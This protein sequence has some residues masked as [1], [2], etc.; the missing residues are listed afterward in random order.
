MDGIVEFDCFLVD[1]KC[2]KLIEKV[3]PPLPPEEFHKQ[4]NSN[5]KDKDY[6]YSKIQEEA[7][8]LGHHSTK[9]KSKDT[10]FKLSELLQPFR[11][12]IVKYQTLAT[13]DHYNRMQEEK[14]KLD[15]L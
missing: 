9:V 5:R 12:M 7:E 14:S 11:N 13:M 10:S 8:E 3:N 2:R 1:P 4:F 6:Y 15:E